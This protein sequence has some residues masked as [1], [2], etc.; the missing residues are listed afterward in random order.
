MKKTKNIYDLPFPPN[1][2][3]A[4][5]VKENQAHTGSFKGAVD[6]AV[7]LQTPVLAPLD[8]EVLEVVD[9]ND[10][11]GI[12]EEFAPYANFITIKH[13]NNEFS[14]LLH[15]EKGSSLVRAGE[16]VKKGNQIALTGNSGWMTNPHIHMFVFKLVPK[17]D[18]F[19][20]LEIR[21]K[22]KMQ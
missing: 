14:Q 19:E 20:G 9:S 16:K 17:G 5:I 7:K 11:F 18:G 15:L 13:T 6:F 21:F 3:V 1:T 2:K 8:G 10:K 22:K 4:F 12:T